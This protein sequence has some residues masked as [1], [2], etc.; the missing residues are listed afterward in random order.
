VTIARSPRR[1]PIAATVVFAIAC[2]VFASIVPLSGFASR[3]GLLA[4]PPTGSTWDRLVSSSASPASGSIPLASTPYTLAYDNANGDL[5]IGT[6]SDTVTIVSTSNNTTL[7]SIGL[8][9]GVTSYP[10]AET[11]SAANGYVYVAGYWT[12]TCTGCNGAWIV[13]IDGSTNNIVAT[14]TSLEGVDVSNYVSCLGPGPI[15][16]VVYACD[17]PDS[18]LLVDSTTV[19]ISGSVAVGSQP[20]SVVFDSGNG[21]TYVV[22]RVTDNVTVIRAASESVAGS[23]SV[24]TEPKAVAYDPVSGDLYV[25]NN[26]SGSVSVINGALDD[27]VATIPVGC[28]PDALAYDVATGNVYVADSC[29]DNL[30][31]ISGATNRVVGSI[32]VG[33]YPAAVVYATSTQDLYV[34]NWGSNNLTIVTGSVQGTPQTYPLEFKESGLPSGLNWSV[35]VNG[36]LESSTSSTIDLEVPNGTYVWAAAPL[37]RFAAARPAGQITVQGLGVDVAIGY[38]FTSWLLVNVQGLPSGV[39]WHLTVANATNVFSVAETLVGSTVAIA[40]VFANWTYT[41]SI[42]FP[43]NF[44][45]WDESGRV[46]VGT[47]NATIGVSITSGSSESAASSNFLWIALVI[48][49]AVS[50]L[51]TIAGMRL[52]KP[53]PPT[54]SSSPPPPAT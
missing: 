39:V 23:V 12:G 30:T 28:G 42:T 9:S 34:A 49:L 38:S 43:A 44:S 18:L 27:V 41:Y 45:A 31:V 21:K 25:A 19:A 20:F 54:R 2:L 4:P 48:G 26:Q 46:A 37:A 32:P 16:S 11:F 50:A 24:G 13:A 40:S 33:I 3:S 15:G 53:R 22:N 10:T 7:G 35:T 1:V 36:H 5:Y 52:Q 29:S 47:S 17:F 51:A 8:P 6:S 14:N